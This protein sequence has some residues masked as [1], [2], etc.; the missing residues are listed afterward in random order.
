MAC[1]IVLAIPGIL[2]EPKNNKITI[3]MTTISDPATSPK[4]NGNKYIKQRYDL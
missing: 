4:N 2:F 3:K 1:P